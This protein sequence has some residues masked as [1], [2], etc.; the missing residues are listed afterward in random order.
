[1]SDEIRFDYC[2]F[3][4]KAKFFSGSTELGVMFGVSR[5]RADEVLKIVEAAVHSVGAGNKEEM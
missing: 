5:D 2:S 1:M 4:Q 3:L